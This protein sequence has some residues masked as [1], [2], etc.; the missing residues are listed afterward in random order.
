VGEAAEGK[1]KATAAAGGRV[2]GVEINP[3]AMRMTPE[4]LGG[5]L[6]TAVNAA[7]KDLR[8]KTAEA[9]GDAV[10][11]TTLAK[12]AEEIQT[13]GLRQMAVFDQAITEALSKIRGGR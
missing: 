9:A 5:H 8:S 13:E 11:A 10:N 2:K 1:V 6:V 7:L 4:E 12:Q 3:R